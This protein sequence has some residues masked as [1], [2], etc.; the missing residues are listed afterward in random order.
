MS[1]REKRGSRQRERE[2][3]G[4]LVVTHPLCAD[5]TGADQRDQAPERREHSPF[6]SNLFAAEQRAILPTR[7]LV[8]SSLLRDRGE[9]GPVW[10]LVDH[11]GPEGQF[12]FSFSCHG[13]RG[14][15]HG[16]ADLM[17]IRS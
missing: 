11:I 17:Q 5:R 3:I 9:W 7:G 4:R 14:D 16:H 15:S 1:Q 10:S 6:L 12:D 13:L 8:Y 2:Q